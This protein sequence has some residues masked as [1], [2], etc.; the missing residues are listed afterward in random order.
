MRGQADDLRPLISRANSSQPKMLHSP[1]SETSTRSAPPEVSRNVNNPN[2]NKVPLP[3]AA[4]TSSSRNS[5]AVVAGSDDI[6]F[7]SSRVHR[8]DVP[9]VPD[10]SAGAGAGG[11][12]GA[13]APVYPTSLALMLD[14]THHTDEICLKYGIG[15]TTL[16]IVLKHLGGGGGGGGASGTSNNA[17]GGGGGGARTGRGTRHGDDED[18]G[19]SRGGGAARRSSRDAAT[20]AN[21]YDK[22]GY[23]QNVVMLWI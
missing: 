4:T 15:S 14:G 11:A 13:T 18:I 19:Q 2:N 22:S 1:H 9:A 21:G 6:G 10:S 20:G 23:G 17:A 3:G 7:E 12:S 16:S 8:D 5:P